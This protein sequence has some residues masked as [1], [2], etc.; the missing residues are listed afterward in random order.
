MAPKGYCAFLIA[1]YLILSH[2]NPGGLNACPTQNSLDPSYLWEGHIPPDAPGLLELYGEVTAVS[3]TQ[4]T[5]DT[6][7]RKYQ[8]PISPDTQIYCNGLSAVWAALRPVTPEAFF[9]AII[10]INQQN[11]VISIAGFYLGEICILKS[12]RMEHN[13]LFLKLTTPDNG[14]TYWRMAASHAKFPET[15]W[16]AEDIEIYVLYDYKKKIRAVFFPE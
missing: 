12:W 15:N 14:R 5:I 9:E 1:L 10:R 3:A 7:T 6:G 8:L 4:I 16:M 13:T 2:V 11:E